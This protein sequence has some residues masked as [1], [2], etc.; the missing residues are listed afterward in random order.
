[1]PLS[2][3]ALLALSSCAIGPATCLA[4]A[5]S[6]PPPP[7]SPPPPAAS[8]AKPPV[9]PASALIAT[10]VATQTPREQC[11]GLL[12]SKYA[13][14]E[15]NGVL[16]ELHPGMSYRMLGVYQGK[17]ATFTCQVIDGEI[18]HEK[19]MGAGEVALRAQGRQRSEQDARVHCI[20]DAQTAYPGIS[21]DIWTSGVES[22]EH[23]GADGFRTIVDGR[24]GDASFRIACFQAPDQPQQH[25]LYALHPLT[26]EPT[27]IT[28]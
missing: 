17:G 18:T 4:L 14:Y 8:Q 7:A 25:W 15:W 21:W 9:A 5:V 16:Q 22:Y 1:M 24:R 28:P 20:R 12:H 6:A 13:A 27:E 19:V 11:L 10:A 23:A 26:G 3:K 2:R